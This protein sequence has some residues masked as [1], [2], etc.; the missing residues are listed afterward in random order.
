MATRVSSRSLIWI[1]KF[2]STCPD[3]N[4]NRFFLQYTIYSSGKIDFS[5]TK[6]LDNCPIYIIVMELKY[7]ESQYL[8]PEVF[9]HLQYLY[10]FP[11]VFENEWAWVWTWYKVLVIASVLT[12]MSVT[13]CAY[14]RI[15]ICIWPSIWR[16]TSAQPPQLILIIIIVNLLQMNVVIGEFYPSHF[17]VAEIVSI[18]FNAMASH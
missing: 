10:F 14:M 3:G 18:I 13:I 8:N 7:I 16:Y 4:K 12:E 6:N 11:V 17:N 1:I 2:L 5:Q 9:D 15:S